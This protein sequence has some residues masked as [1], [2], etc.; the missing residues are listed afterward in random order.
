[1]R[2]RVARSLVAVGMAA[3]AVVAAPAAT[4]TDAA[5]ANHSVS[6]TSLHVVSDN[7]LPRIT[8]KT[9]TGR[10]FDLGRGQTSCCY[11][12][13]Y[14]WVPAGRTLQWGF[15]DDGVTQPWYESGG[16]WVSFPDTPYHAFFRE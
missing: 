7:P 11:P 8:F 3:A 6:D 13:G 1:M 14:V 12:G 15:Y 4:G 5:Q 10:Q 2:A 9:R 16:R